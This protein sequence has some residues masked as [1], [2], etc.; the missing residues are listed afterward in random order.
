[1]KKK[2][3]KNL[4]MVSFIALSM[5]MVNSSSFVSAYASNGQATAT[6]YTFPAE[7]EKQS[8]VWLVWQS[9]NEFGD[10]TSPEQHKVTAQIIEALHSHNTKVELILQTGGESKTDVLNFLSDYNV[11]PA[12]INFREYK[13]SYIFMRDM[14]PMFLKNSE[15]KAKI[16]DFEWNMYGIWKRGGYTNRIGNVDRDMAQELDIPTLSSKVVVEGGAVEFNGEGVMMTYKDTALQRNPGLTIEEIEQE[17]LRVFG[18]K[19]MIWLE[20]SPISDV[21]TPDGSPIME[22]FFGYGANGHVDEFVRF[23]DA[24]TILVAEI[25]EEARDNNNLERIDYERIEEVVDTLEAATDINGQPFNIIR[26]PAPDLSLLWNEHTVQSGDIYPEFGFQPGD[27]VF[28]IPAVSYLNFLISNGVVISAKYWEPGM[29][30]KLRQLDEQAKAALQSVFP[31]RE[32]VQ[33]NPI[34]INWWGGGIHCITQQQPE[35]VK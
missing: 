11:D 13:D 12:N 27:T 20:R 18:Q 6:G 8:A 22:N 33:I 24:D 15:G 31:D 5:I 21:L 34:A 19:K 26:V 3:W 28:E 14:G 17:Y 25:S 1:M 32:I 2:F 4:C 23:V 10:T 29:P 30:D 7:W 9:T 35:Y 16:A